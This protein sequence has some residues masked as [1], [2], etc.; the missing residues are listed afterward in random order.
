MLKNRYYIIAGEPSGDMH[1]AN[2][3]K[4]MYRINPKLEI[5]GFGGE[6]MAKAGVDITRDLDKLS[7]VG[8]FEILKHLK[9]I[10]EN[11]DIAKKDILDFKPK[12]IILIDYPGFNLR[13]AKWAKS[14]G[15]KI[16]YYI[17]P[18][19]WAWGKG[20][21]KKIKKYIDK[22][23]VILPFEEDFFRKNNIN[24]EYSG[25]P[26]LD[27]ISLFKMEDDF[28][29]KNGIPAIKKIVAF[30]PGSRQSEIDKH[31]EAVLPVIKKNTDMFF[32]V[33]ARKGLNSTKLKSLEQ[34]SN[35]KVFF[36]E[37]YKILNVSDAGVIKS[38]TS[39]LEAAFFEL[40]QIVIYKMNPLSYILVKLLTGIKY[41]SLV[42]LILEKESV[43]EL[44]QFDFTSENVD[45]ELKALFDSQKR[46]K[47]LRDYNVLKGIIKRDKKAS[48]LVAQSI[49][50][51]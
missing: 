3:V 37:T 40:P 22:L 36:D 34:L 13:I 9:T 18:Q 41:A 42:N 8:F 7:F 26:L 29:V 15:I 5:K 4:A 1:A 2:L 28:L 33:A 14:K 23:F 47:I 51:G 31:I 38:G 48:E 30:L 10:K 43:K 45:K 32:L 16:Y 11:F 27:E 25:H 35:V 24:A 19:V 50:N 46:E 39:S 49:L 21:I 20:R 6:K 12:A 44:I 17:A